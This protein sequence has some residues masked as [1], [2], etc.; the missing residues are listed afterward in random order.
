MF[1]KKML[2]R[3]FVNVTAKLSPHF[4]ELGNY[5]SALSF[6]GVA[7]WQRCR[8]E[9]YECHNIL[10]VTGQLNKSIEGVWTIY[11]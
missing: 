9:L 8:M 4:L 5:K 6:A 11:K 7:N 10:K 2:M 1:P 3:K